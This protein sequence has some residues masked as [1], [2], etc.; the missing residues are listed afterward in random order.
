MPENPITQQDSTESVLAWHWL[1]ADRKLRYPPHTVVEVGVTLHA[2]GPLRLCKNGLHGSVRAVDSLGYEA[3]P[4]ICRTRH[5]GAILRGDDK[6][7]STERTALW[8]ADGA[9]ALRE[10]VLRCAAHVLPIYERRFPND[11]RVRRCVEATRQY[12][13][14]DLPL[15][16][17]RP[18]RLAARSAAH[19]AAPFDHAAA[20]AAATA[21]A[22]DS[23]AAAATRSAAPA[24]YAAVYSAAYGAVFG[25][26][27]GADYA[28]AAAA[29]A[30][31]YGAAAAG[32]QTERA[33]QEQ[34][35]SE[36][37]LALAPAGA[38]GVP[39]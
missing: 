34:Q 38:E 6:L 5:S 3:G 33:W 28:A 15:E 27:Y 31:D 39:S 26:A 10:F 36:L 37:L 29:Y 24:D 17:L 23:V 14:G 2:D 9:A 16:D 30:A 8:I 13:A 19:S 20:Y 11:D 1:A 12:L 22:A 35:L 4:T 25:A 7:C 21:Y 32:R 18:T